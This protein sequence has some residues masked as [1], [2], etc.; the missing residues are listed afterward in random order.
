MPA[1]N[2][3]KAIRATEWVKEMARIRSRPTIINI[4]LGRR[5]EK[6]SRKAR[7]P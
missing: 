6:A 7:R 5:G 2:T 3:A 4:A 1:L